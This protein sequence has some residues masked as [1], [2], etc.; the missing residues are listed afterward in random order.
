MFALKVKKNFLCGKKLVY[1]RSENLGI[2]E[3]T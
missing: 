1:L 2:F 3:K